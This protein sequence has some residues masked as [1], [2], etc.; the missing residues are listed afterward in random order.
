MLGSAAAAKIG[1]MIAFGLHRMAF[2]NRE[3]LETKFVSVTLAM[4]VPG[5]RVF[6]TFGAVFWADFVCF[7]TMT[8]ASLLT[9][10][11]L[12]GRASWLLCTGHGRVRQWPHAHEN[13]CW[14]NFA[15]AI[16][17]S[18]ILARSNKKT[19]SCNNTESKEYALDQPVYALFWSATKSP[20][21]SMS[22]QMKP[23]MTFECAK[24]LSIWTR[25][26]SKG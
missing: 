7:G 19:W 25:G 9:V 2:M 15:A 18:V 14:W 22:R 12:S 11:S 4:L 6:L 23:W 26:G 17:S 13:R 10:F 1:K 5:F 3:G 16:D 8:G 20:E 21:T 24:K